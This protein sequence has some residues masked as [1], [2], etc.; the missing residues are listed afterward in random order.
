MQSTA[1]GTNLQIKINDISISYNDLG[2]GD[3][4]I[5]F[6]HGFPFDKSMW[7]LQMEFLKS[8]HRVITYDIRGY[9]KSTLGSE[10]ASIDLFA[11][12]LIEFMNIH[13]ISILL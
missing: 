11:D 9:G 13:R 10:K 8:S 12:D 1:T 4:P 3:M 6:I 2:E 7:Q 5:I